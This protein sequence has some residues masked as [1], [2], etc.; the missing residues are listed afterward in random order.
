MKRY[1]IVLCMLAVMCLFIG[2]TVQADDIAGIAVS[3]KT[4]QSAVKASDNPKAL[5]L[6]GLT[7][8]DGFIVDPDNKDIVLY[9]QS[10]PSQ[11]ALYFDDFVVALRNVNLG[12]AQLSGNTYYYTSPGC[13]IDPDPAII[14]QLQE[15]RNQH[16]DGK[17]IDQWNEVGASPQSVR[18]NGI[19]FTTRFAK[20]MVDADYYMKKLVNGSEDPGVYGFQS[21]MGM[22][23]DLAKVQKKNG[24][25]APDS[26]A[27]INRFWFYPGDC[28]YAFNDNIAALNEC[29]VKL[30]TELEYLADSGKIASTGQSDAL[31][32]KFADS[33]TANYGQIAEFN[34]VYKE[35]E[36][37]FRFVGLA[38][39]LNETKAEKLSGINISFINKGYNVKN[40]VVAKQLPGLTNANEIRNKQRIDGGYLV[41][42]STFVSCGGVSIDMHP[43]RNATFSM[44]YPVQDIRQLSKTI[45]TDRSSKSALSWPFKVTI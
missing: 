18:V 33:F 11:P 13:S 9:G 34:P 14:R 2:V 7:R 43:F 15:I 26:G 10:D 39:M 40:T 23:I 42:T 4:L 35:L 45:L 20:V 21:L 29:N 44:R 27:S 24:T 31:A 25:R 41:T 38:K 37:L 16:E 8:I 3:M 32:Q 36:N 30:L 12:Y 5:T 22:R 19:P 17:W 28:L 1:T 6:A